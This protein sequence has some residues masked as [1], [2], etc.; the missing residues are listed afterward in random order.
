M[1]D[2]DPATPPAEF[3][4]R[5]LAAFLHDPPH[6][7][8]RIAGHEDVR[9]SALIACDLTV[10]E[11]RRWQAQPDWAAAAADRF[12]FPDPDKSGVRTDWRD[13]NLAFIHPLAGT[14]LEP[15]FLPRTAAVGEDWV[16]GTLHGIADE[17]HGYR[18]NFL[19]L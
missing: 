17:A 19:R 18:K 10:D 3:W 1:F 9:A 5:K 2:P 7:P 14:R 16:N 15:T 8:F 13:D 4:K 12:I 11:M 6:K